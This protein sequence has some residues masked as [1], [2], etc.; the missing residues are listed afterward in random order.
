MWP[1]GHDWHMSTHDS[2]E[3]VAHVWSSHSPQQGKWVTFIFCKKPSEICF[4]GREQQAP[5]GWVPDGSVGVCLP[6]VCALGAGRGVQSWRPDL[7]VEGLR[8]LSPALVCSLHRVGAPTRSNAELFFL[9]HSLMDM[10]HLQ[11]SKNQIKF[12]YM[13][14]WTYLSETNDSSRKSGKGVSHF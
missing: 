11:R 2:V 4:A 14:K 5:H 7:R 12:H 8:L 13:L 1:S 3:C 9:M 10:K 6:V